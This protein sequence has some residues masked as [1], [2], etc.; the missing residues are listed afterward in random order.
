MSSRVLT[1]GCSWCSTATTCSPFGSVCTWYGGNFTSRAGNGRG[2]ASDGQLCCAETRETPQRHSDMEFNTPQSHGVTEK[3]FIALWL[4]D[5][6]ADPLRVL[7]DL[8]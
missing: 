2:G 1:A 4:C 5:S 8:C 3:P 7:N 6:V